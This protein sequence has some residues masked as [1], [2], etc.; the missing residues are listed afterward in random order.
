M[1]C[2]GAFVALG[3]PRTVVVVRKGA[4]E[5]SR[6]RVSVMTSVERLFFVVAGFLAL[7]FVALLAFVG[8]KVTSEPAPLAVVQAAQVVD[9][10]ADRSATMIKVATAEDSVSVVRAPLGTPVGDAVPVFLSADNTWEYGSPRESSPGLASLVGALFGVAIV[11]ALV[12]FHRASR[13]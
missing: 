5:Q 2:G 4:C 11:G 3:L 10:D 9:V 12:A 1:A 8:Y 7:A 6:K 13:W